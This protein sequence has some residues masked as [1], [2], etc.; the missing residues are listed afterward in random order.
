MHDG[1]V[2]WSWWRFALMTRRDGVGTWWL[3]IRL[4]DGTYPTK[5]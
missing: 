2:V 3:V 5:D 4:H 1:K